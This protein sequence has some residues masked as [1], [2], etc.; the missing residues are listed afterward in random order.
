MSGA[1][2]RVWVLTFG[3]RPLVRRGF[4][5]FHTSQADSLRVCKFFSFV[6]S[7]VASYKSRGMNLWV[8]YLTTSFCPQFPSYRGK[9][10]KIS[11]KSSSKIENITD[12]QTELQ[13]RWFLM[14]KK[15]SKMI[16][17]RLRKS[18]VYIQTHCHD[19]NSDE[20]KIYPK[21]QPIVKKN[22]STNF[23]WF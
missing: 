16:Q 20:I 3:H 18:K 22:M 9:A 12:R 5:Y 10:R 7:L 1:V 19:K 11:L 8:I 13:H 2:W 17:D 14:H 4:H 23:K 21:I 15:K 6:V